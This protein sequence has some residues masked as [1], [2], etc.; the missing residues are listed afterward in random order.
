MQ[1]KYKP[2]CGDGSHGGSRFVKELY[3]FLEPTGLT[4]DC[5]SGIGSKTIFMKSKGIEV[6]SID[7]DFRSLRNL[8]EDGPG[9][10]ICGD[11]QYLPFKDNIFDSVMCSE[12]LEHLPYPELCI[13]E[14]YRVTKKNGVGVF[15]TPVFNLHYKILIKIFRKICGIEKDKSHLHVFS[16]LSLNKLISKYFIIDYILH[17]GYTEILVIKFGLDK[18][19]TF[20]KKLVVLSKKLP[21][22]KLLSS[23]VWVRVRKE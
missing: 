13:N 10:I 6:V 20:D 17:R 12:V 19:G 22:I 1:S 16:I 7:I 4:L 9:S 18:N 2:E 5:G 21:F 14:V 8:A 11:V 3:D 23:K 15:T